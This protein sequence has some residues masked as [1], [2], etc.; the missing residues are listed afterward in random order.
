MDESTAEEVA[1]LLLAGRGPAEAAT[2]AT[3]VWQLSGWLTA[4]FAY[5]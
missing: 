4:E 2:V 3:I 1:E 5:D